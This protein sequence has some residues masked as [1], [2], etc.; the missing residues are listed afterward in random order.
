VYLPLRHSAAS[1]TDVVAVWAWA[2]AAP[3]TG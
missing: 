2:W 3:W 1:Y